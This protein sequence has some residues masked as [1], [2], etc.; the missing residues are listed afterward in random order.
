MRVAVRHTV[1]FRVFP[2]DRPGVEGFFADVFDSPVDFSDGCFPARVSRV[3]DAGN[4]ELG[5]PLVQVAFVGRMH[6]ESVKAAEDFNGGWF[7]RH[8]SVVLCSLGL[9]YKRRV[10]SL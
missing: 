10:V 3:D 1:A 8:N 7:E 9:V 6:A 4:F 5:V 2:G